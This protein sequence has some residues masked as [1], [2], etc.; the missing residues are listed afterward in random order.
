MKQVAVLKE[1]GDKAGEVS[2]PESWFGLQPN[3]S[4]VYYTVKGFLTNQRQGN[5][6]TKE[7]GDLAYSNRKPWRQKGTGRAR[8]GSRRSPLWR[9]GGTMFGPHPKNYEVRTSKRV[10]RTALLSALS[11]KAAEEG[12]IVVVEN[13]EFDQPKTARA[14]QALRNAGVGDCRVLI[15][16]DGYKPVLLK[17]VRNLQKVVLKN[18]AECNAYDVLLAEKLVIEKSII[19]KLGSQSDERPA[20]DN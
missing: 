3:P 5:A 11:A 7:R 4:V 10:R 16:C 12:A 13:F 8:A 9:G 2:L 15:M 18:F 19:E 17:S 20:S 1:N 14:L 6:D